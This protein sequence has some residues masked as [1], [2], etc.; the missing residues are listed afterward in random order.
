MRLA[1]PADGGVRGGPMTGSEV[2]YVNSGGVHIAYRVFGDGPVDLVL[3]PAFTSHLEQNHEWPGVVRW[4]ARLVSFSRLIVFDKRSTGLSDHAPGP[5]VLEDTMQDVLAVL[6][7]AG[8]ER[9]AVCGDLEGA[10]LSALFAA[11]HPERTRALILYAPL[12]FPWALAPEL[13]HMFGE[14]LP[15]A[16]GSEPMARTL[17]GVVAPSLADDQQFLQFMAKAMRSSVSPGAAQAWLR[18]ISD[19]DV[20]EALPQIRVPTLIVHRTGDRAVDVR[21]SRYAASRI[22]GARLVELPGGDNLTF[23]G[24]S[25]AVA[26]EIEEFLTGS[27]T[28]PMPDRVLATILFTDI[29]G[30]TERAAEVGDR[31]WRELLGRHDTLTR[32]QLERYRGREV[33]MTG[34][35]LLATFDGPARAVTC[36]GAIGREMRALGL[37]VRAAVHTGEVELRDGD[38][39]GIA[40]HIAARVMGLA[41]PNEVLVSSTVKDLVAGAEIRFEDRSVQSLRGVPGQWQLFAAFPKR[42]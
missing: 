16:W 29:A 4:N 22:P 25:E 13:Q 11:T 6:D 5:V 3:V 23:V 14:Q 15:A 41:R 2:R 21:S 9:P 32:E 17:A 26:A 38:I 39:G 12:V 35:G 18:M 7:A 40:V 27:V 8:A 19:I 1:G 28:P 36:A 33:K 30:S 42:S 10:A 20:R 37:E 24:D 34:D 31:R